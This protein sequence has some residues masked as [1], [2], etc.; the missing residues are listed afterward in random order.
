MQVRM[1]LDKYGKRFGTQVL[2]CFSLDR[3]NFATMLNDKVN[4]Q[5][6]IIAKVEYRGVLHFS[7]RTSKKN[8]TFPTELLAK[9]YIFPTEH[10]I[11]A[12]KMQ[13]FTKADLGQ[14]HE[15]RR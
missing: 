6:C 1:L 8:H 14:K 7:Y 3:Y 15:S 13:L 11:F 9:I 12:E 2:F 5:L 10:G 4:F